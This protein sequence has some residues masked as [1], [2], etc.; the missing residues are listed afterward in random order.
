MDTDGFR[1][2]Q[3]PWFFSQPSTSQ[4]ANGAL[5]VAVPKKQAL[6]TE[7]SRYPGWAAPM[8]DGRLVTDYRQ[9]CELNIP[10]GMQY[11]YRIFMQDN[12]TDIIDKSRRRQ[13][14]ATG[15]GKSY[16]A[17]SDMPNH[18]IAQCNKYECFV[19]VVNKNGIGIA[20]NENVPDLFGTFAP[21]Y[22]AV[23][24]TNPRLTS[25]SEGGRNSI[26]TF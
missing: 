18:K 23:K 8:E 16:D 1:K 3:T 7:D 22:S 11:G 10:T 13:A 5:N 20:R 24:N 4:I 9:N 2:T 6:P 25:V 21:S 17:V 26:R 15:A 19:K 12:A 14:A